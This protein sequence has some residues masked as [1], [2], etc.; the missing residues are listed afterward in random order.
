MY[1]N[2]HTLHKL[3]CRMREHLI[4]YLTSYWTNYIQLLYVKMLVDDMPYF[5]NKLTYKLLEMPEAVTQ[6]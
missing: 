6:C 1:M 2:Q 3:Q 4:Y 5:T